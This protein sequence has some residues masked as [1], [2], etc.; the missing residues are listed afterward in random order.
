MK[1]F[2]HD[3]GDRFSDRRGDGKDQYGASQAYGY[4]P[5]KDQNPGY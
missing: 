4:D 1:T 5:A 3:S 2:T